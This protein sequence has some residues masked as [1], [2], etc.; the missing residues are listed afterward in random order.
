M[1][2]GRDERGELRVLAHEPDAIRRVGG[3]ERHVR[4]ARP[5]Y[6]QDGLD[7]RHVA[8]KKDADESIAPRIGR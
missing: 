6:P 5:K 2:G 3:I 7:Q 4:G 1:A 8:I